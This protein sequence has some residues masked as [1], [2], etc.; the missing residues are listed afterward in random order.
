MAAGGFKAGSWFL[1]FSVLVFCLLFLLLVW[2]KFVRPGFVFG[3]SS[4]TVTPTTIPYSAVPPVNGSLVEVTNLS[5]R[6]SRG[7]YESYDVSSAEVM[8]YVWE[9]NSILDSGDVSSCRKLASLG[10]GELVDQ[11]FFK[12]AHDE[13]NLSKCELLTGKALRD[14]CFKRIGELRVGEGLD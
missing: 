9:V 10:K 8:N 13:R 7:G 3:V 2:Y 6:Y 14:Y 1:K 12:I 5:G 4:T 11:C